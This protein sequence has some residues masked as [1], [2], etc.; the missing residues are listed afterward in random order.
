MRYYL[1]DSISHTACSLGKQHFTYSMQ[2]GKAAFHIQHAVWESSISHTA[3][4]LGKQHFTYRM[5]FGKAAFHIQHAV[6]ESS[7]SHTACSLGSSISHTACSL[8]K[9]SFMCSTF[10]L[11]IPHETRSLLVIFVVVRKCD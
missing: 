10:P 4:S 8:G 9:H 11:A 2:F 1:H 7:I 5:R 6:W 3:C